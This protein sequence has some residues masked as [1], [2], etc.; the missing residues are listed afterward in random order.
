MSGDYAPCTNKAY[1]KAISDGAN[2]IDC[3]VHMSEDGILLCMI[4]ANLIDSTTI[5]SSNFSSLVKNIPEIQSDEGIF[6]FELTW[7]QIQTLTRKFGFI[8]L[9]LIAAKI[10][11]SRTV[12][13]YKL[14]QSRLIKLLSPDHESL[15]E[16]WTN[17]ESKVPERRTLSQVVGLL[18][19]GKKRKFCFG[20]TD[21]NRGNSHFPKHAVPLNILES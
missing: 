6:S 16:V 7:A 10:L 4:S 13:R 20:S 17:A 14:M 1:L 12:D 11:R 21:K 8:H 3:P 5:L 18:G 15:L 2:V 9:D 19:F